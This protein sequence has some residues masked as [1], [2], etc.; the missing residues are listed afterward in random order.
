VN[1]LRKNLQALPTKNLKKKETKEKE[2]VRN[3]AEMFGT[4][5]FRG[6]NG[7][8]GSQ[9]TLQRLQAR[10]VNAL[11]KNLQALPTKDQKKKETKEKETVR[12]S[13]VVLLVIRV[14]WETEI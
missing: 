11:R 2:K 9:S 13:S 7:R 12:L 3:G 4:T 14:F 10:P 1:A 6:E 8:R 5:S